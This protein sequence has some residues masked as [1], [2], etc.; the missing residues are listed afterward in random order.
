LLFWRY[1]FV[2]VR[3]LIIH[4]ALPPDIVGGKPP[5][6]YSRPDCMLRWL[7]CAGAT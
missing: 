1:R 3:F 2:T 5:R 6:S 7:T 4:E